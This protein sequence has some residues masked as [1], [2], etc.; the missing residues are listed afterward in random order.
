[1]FCCF[2]ARLSE[3]ACTLGV[4]SPPAR[5]AQGAAGLSKDTSQAQTLCQGQ[6]RS[7]ISA[8]AH[9]SKDG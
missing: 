7:K 4:P 5:P 9:S 1:M 6:L 3:I 8:Q 2:S